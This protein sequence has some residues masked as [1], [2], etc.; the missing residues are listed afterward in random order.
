MTNWL[1][2]GVSPVILVGFS[3]SRCRG[4]APDNKRTPVIPAGV[5]GNPGLFSSVPLFVRLCLGKAMDSRLKTSGMTEGGLKTSGM[6]E[7]DCNGRA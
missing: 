6:M 3:D 2:R 5:S 7:G 4:Q 1:K